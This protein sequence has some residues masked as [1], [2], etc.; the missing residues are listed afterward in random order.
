MGLVV[1]QTPDTS[2]Q[3]EWL[4]SARLVNLTTSTPQPITL[5]VTLETYAL[6][7]TVTTG[8]TDKVTLTL[9]PE[10]GIEYKFGMPQNGTMRYSWRASEPIMSELHGDRIEH[11]NDYTTFRAKLAQSDE[12][13]HVAPFEGRHGWYWRNPT[14]KTV[15]IELETS[16]DYTI[17]GVPR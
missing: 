7:T 13:T 1:N 15:T 3:G 10:R 17:I 9:L 16:G 4:V 8:P 2:A 11:A 6:E 5:S 14:G 12:G